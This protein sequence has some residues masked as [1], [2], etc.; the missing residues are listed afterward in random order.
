MTIGVEY[1]QLA[2]YETWVLWHL[3]EATLPET[4]QIQVEGGLIAASVCLP[5]CNLIYE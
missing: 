5:W 3:V 1:I 4:L 2:L